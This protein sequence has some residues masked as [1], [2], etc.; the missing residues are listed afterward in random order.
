MTPT[1]ISYLTFGIV[2][3]VALIFDFGL[4]SKRNSHVTMRSAFYQSVF[5]V[6]FSVAFCVFLFFEDGS[7]VAT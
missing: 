5:W 1:E 3:L 6:L 4:F 2:L 7:D